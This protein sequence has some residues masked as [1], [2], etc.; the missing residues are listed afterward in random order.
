MAFYPE[1]PKWDQNPT[2]TP[3]SE[4]MSIL[5]PFI[6]ESPPGRLHLGREYG[7]VILS[8]FL[9]ESTKQQIKATLGLT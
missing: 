9:W 6:W 5:A 3:L 8:H 1:R 4:T 2:L 7:T